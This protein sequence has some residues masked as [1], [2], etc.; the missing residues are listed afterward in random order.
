MS[1]KKTK[2]YTTDGTFAEK[3]ESAGQALA[4]E[5][6][7]RKGYRVTRV[8]VPRAPRPMSS[9][10]IARLRKRLNCSQ[11][12]FARALNVSTR[13]IQAWEQGARTPRDTALKLLTIARKHP[14]VLL[15]A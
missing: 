7:A 8:A 10:E 6:G 12:V 13:T 1:G 4:Y 9:E 3:M 2:T 11:S 14:E 5:R 15:E